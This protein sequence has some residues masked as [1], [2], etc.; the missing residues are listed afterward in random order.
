MPHQKRNEY[1]RTWFRIVL[2]L[3]F[4]V[5]AARV[6]AQEKR[7]PPA[8][9]L[10][11][12]STVGVIFV[13]DVPRLE[14]QWEKTQIGTLLRDPVMEPFREDIRRQFQDRWLKIE[15]KFGLKLDDIRGIAGGEVALALARVSDAKAAT[16]ALVDVTE[17]GP[18][19]D[20]MLE[21]ARAHLTRKGARPEEHQVEDTKVIVFDL[22]PE[23]N[24]TSGQT[25]VYFLSGNLLGV[26][27]DLDVT[28]QI[29]ARYFG[30][31]SR[32]LSD[33]AAYRYTMARCDKAVNSRI[34]QLR[35]FVDPIGYA[36]AMDLA[37]AEREERT[38]SDSS[39]K[40][41][42]AT[43]RRQGFDAVKG[44]GGYVDFA[45]G[46]Y[47]SFH[48]TAVCAPGPHKPA[49][50]PYEGVIPM[51]MFVFP[52]ATEFNPP[53]W[54]PEDIAACTVFYWDI[55]RAFRN[56][57]PLFDELYGEGETGI[58][59]DVLESWAGEELGPRIDVEE[60][61][62]A[63]LGTRVI[64][65]TDYRLPITT[66]S[67]RTLY[68]V[69]ARNPDAVAAG[70]QKLLGTDPT[71]RLREIEGHRIWESF[72]KE[73]K[74][75]LKIDVQPPS[76][77]FGIDE[78]DLQEDAE[79]DEKL[80]PNNAVTVVDGYLLV[81][82]HLDIL[83]KVLSGGEPLSASIDYRLVSSAIDS[84]S[85]PPRCLQTFT[86]TDEQYRAT[87][88]LIRLGKMPENESLFARLL[89]I[90]IPPEEG[91]GFRSQRID[92]KELPEYQV[93]RRYLGPATR[94]V[95]SEK[96]GWFEFGFTL[97]K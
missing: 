95:V 45:I 18:Q 86:R 49:P 14:S 46:A 62:I 88:E 19:V 59:Q 22:P 89:N 78:E 2:V 85:P 51:E 16:I 31:E 7:V 63:H 69:E 90:L 10:L 23:G 94:I 4:A 54:V 40:D 77:T 48:H 6:G 37:T 28:K 72:E 33:V 32:S 13:P 52:N 73:R 35:W 11:P 97:P 82:S 92:G 83:L 12:E 96:D 79:A 9:L 17:H 25:A 36:E 61:L 66:T 27:D 93:V 75:G 57:G 39:V 20:R 21:K 60:E 87:Y 68:A 70:I 44:I 84:L 42:I 26:A 71:Y 74:K 5:Q 1:T 67:Q 50:E 58:W 24:E 91:K 56:F 3:L 41:T 65:L 80:F 15:R 81:A 29:L 47:E 64:V 38:S 53:K 34:P 55:A 76:L 43:A 8:D 30:K